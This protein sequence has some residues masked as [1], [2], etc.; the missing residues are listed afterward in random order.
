MFDLGFSI[1]DLLF[2]GL[3]LS[4]LLAWH[5]LKNLLLIQWFSTEIYFCIWTFMLCV[6]GGSL[7]RITKFKLT[8]RYC[9][10]MWFASFRSSGFI[11]GKK[12]KK[13]HLCVLWCN[14]I[15]NSS[16]VVL[17]GQIKPK[18][19]LAR[20]RF[21]QKKKKLI[22]FVYREKQ[23][24]KQNKFV[25]SFFGRIYGAPIC[26]RFY[27]TFTLFHYNSVWYTRHELNTHSMVIAST[28]VTFCAIL[29]EDQ[30][31]RRG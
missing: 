27:L 9:T 3:R 29:R 16:I 13:T 20:R 11:S 12:T 24:S 2:H 19:V 6:Y 30:P 25:C 10:E 5:Q 26:F 4:W 21:F 7:D 8:L 15:D 18:V 17:K 23:K 1:F 31:C 28:L 14:L 22:C